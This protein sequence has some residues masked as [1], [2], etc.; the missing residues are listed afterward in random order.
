MAFHRTTP[1]VVS[2]VDRFSTGRLLEVATALTVVL[3]LPQSAADRADALVVATGQGEEWRLSHAIRMWETNPGLRTLL[4]ANGNP[5]EAT[6]V[7]LTADYLRGLGLR[8]VEGVHVQAE[9]AP[10]T[11]LQA[12]WIVDRVR[13][14]GVTSLAVTAS[15]YHLL[16]VYLTILRTMDGSRIPLIPVPT[17]VAPD[18]RVPETGATAYELTPGEVDRILTY[19]DRGW[20]ATPEEL[21]DYLRWLWRHHRSL[22][23][24]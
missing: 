7:E 11:G 8:R 3:S 5:D 22:L 9:P 12:A 4:V 6:Y 18:T 2:D 1:R 20:L 21:R 19:A 10:N 14:L 17:A 13:A 16:R 23:V 15:A 24:G